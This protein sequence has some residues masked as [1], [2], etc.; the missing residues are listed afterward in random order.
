MTTADQNANNQIQAQENGFKEIPNHYLTEFGANNTLYQNRLI[1]QF[2][3]ILT[4]QK[5]KRII[6][7]YSHPGAGKSR[8]LKRIETDRDLLGSDYIPVYIDSRKFTGQKVDDLLTSLHIKIVNKLRSFGYNIPAIDVFNKMREKTTV[9][10]VLISVD[11]HLQPNQNFLLILDEFDKLIDNPI[12]LDAI[13]SLGRFIAFIKRSWDQY[14]LVI[15]GDRKLPLIFADP[16][17][18]PQLAN[19]VEIDIDDTLDENTLKELI[20]N[21]VKNELTYAPDAVD[22]I[23]K[24]CGRNYYFQQILCHYLVKDLN[25]KQKNTCRILDIEPVVDHIAEQKIPELVFA[26]NHILDHNARLIS[27]ALMDDRVVEKI[28]DTYHIKENTLL[29]DLFGDSLESTAK[30]LQV[31]GFIN[32]MEKRRF[33]KFPLQIPLYGMWIKKQHPFL[34]TIL[35]N[36][37]PFASKL[38]LKKITQAIKEAPQEILHPF[39]KNRI[40]ETSKY[41]ITLKDTILRGAKIDFN[42]VEKFLCA[43]C[44]RLNLDAEIEQQTGESYFKVNIKS[45]KI[46]LIKEAIFFLQESRSLT[47][48]DISRIETKATEYAHKTRNALTLFIYF[49]KSGKIEELSKNPLLN[50]IPIDESV[51]SKIILSS[52][53]EEVFKKLV[54]NRVSLQKISPYTV[55]SP[56][57]ITFYGRKNYLDR[58]I[59]AE[60]VSFSIVGTR[61]IGKSSLLNRVKDMYRPGITCIYGCGQRILK[62]ENLWK[63]PPEYGE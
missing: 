61:R 49:E 60:D 25:Q 18:T 52:D 15:A 37:E 55:A 29:D 34:K 58:I 21:P 5:G 41:W 48:N 20:V 9:T 23:I 26:W 16:N 51:V 42:E 17:K 46:G 57:K 36:L 6:V 28:G 53:A 19:S 47:D 8:I 59:N 62:G 44:T 10:D 63:I 38:E 13:S 50:L 3:D 56:V 30:Q 43:F 14:T 24:Q 11:A 40:L 2:K 32:K 39:D 54:I 33:D 4:N 22:S 45:F 7:L 12:S 27:S 35:E 1:N 31:L